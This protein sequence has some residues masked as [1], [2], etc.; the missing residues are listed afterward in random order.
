[1]IF[2]DTFYKVNKRNPSYVHAPLSLKS[3]SGPMQGVQVYSRLAYQCVTRAGWCRKETEKAC[4]PG[5]FA[6]ESDQ[7]HGH[8][9][10]FVK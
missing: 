2:F 3:I 7:A 10:L 6:A 1:M 9:M 5:A 8:P 4:E